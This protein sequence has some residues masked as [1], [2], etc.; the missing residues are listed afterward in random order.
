MLLCGISKEFNWILFLNPQKT[1]VF[2]SRNETFLE[3][4][5]LLDRKGEKIE[6]EE[7]RETPTIIEPTRE[8]PREEIQDHRRSERVS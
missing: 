7:V 4:E 8:E 2:V 1:K 5:F 3:K 6:L